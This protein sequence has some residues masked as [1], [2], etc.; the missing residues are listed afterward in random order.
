M[1]FLGLQMLHSTLFPHFHMAIS[2]PMPQ[3]PN[4]LLLRRTPVVLDLR[5]TLIQ[6]DPHPNWFHW[7]IRSPWQVPGRH[8]LFQDIIQ[9]SAVG[10]F[11]ASRLFKECSQRR[12]VRQQESRR[13]Q[14]RVWWRV[15]LLREMMLWYNQGRS[16]LIKIMPHSCP[17]LRQG[18]WT[19]IP[20]N[21]VHHEIKLVWECGKSQALLSLHMQ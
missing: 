15:S 20:P 18:S 5:H 8:K 14:A 1:A 17:H 16:G 11:C 13:N 4:F 19:V 21:H 7:Q 2:V 6:H 12:P 3:C 9:S 10:F